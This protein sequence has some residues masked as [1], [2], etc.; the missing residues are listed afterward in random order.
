MKSLKG[1]SCRTASAL[2]HVQLA[3]GAS[4]LDKHGPAG[5]QS[6][7]K[8]NNAAVVK[9]AYCPQMRVVTVC[10]SF[11]GVRFRFNQSGY[12]IVV[13]E[14]HATRAAQRIYQYSVGRFSSL[15]AFDVQLRELRV[16]LAS[17]TTSRDVLIYSRE[18][19]SRGL[20]G[21]G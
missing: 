20:D 17:W 12:C 6:V 3:K 1:G 9:Y 10:Y 15:D 21:C 4:I 2:T 8:L 18:R 11:R 16:Q 7:C 13:E 19:T 14:A 5:E